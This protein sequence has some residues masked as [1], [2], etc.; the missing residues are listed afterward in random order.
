MLGAGMKPG[1]S[2]TAIYPA[3]ETLWADQHQRYRWLIKFAD[4]GLFTSQQL[5]NA[6][7]ASSDGKNKEP[8][9]RYMKVQ[10]CLIV[11]M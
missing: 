1:Q 11:S 5:K 9:I 6:I 8:T 10:F 2:G 3:V 7:K 4:C